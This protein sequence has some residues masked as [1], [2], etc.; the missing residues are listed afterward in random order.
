MAEKYFDICKTPSDDGERPLSS[1]V[2]PVVA[3]CCY[4]VSMSRLLHHAP[5]PANEGPRARARGGAGAT[6]DWGGGWGVL[7]L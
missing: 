4:V 5:P 6:G 1:P 7:R 2:S 3:G